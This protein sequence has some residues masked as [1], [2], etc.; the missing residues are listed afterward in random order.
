MNWR[1]I[2]EALDSPRPAGNAPV[3]EDTPDGRTVDEAIGR[4]A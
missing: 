3:G 4:P 2:I 1:L